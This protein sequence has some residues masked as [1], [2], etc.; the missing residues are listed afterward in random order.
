MITTDIG[1]EVAARSLAR[2]VVSLESF[3]LKVVRA[4][5]DQRTCYQ[6]VG[7]FSICPDYLHCAHYAVLIGVLTNTLETPELGCLEDDIYGHSV[8]LVGCK[9][10]SPDECVRRIVGRISSSMRQEV[11]LIASRL[12]GGH[13]LERHALFSGV[14]FE[15]RDLIFAIETEAMTRPD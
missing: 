6:F 4:S 15:P 1:P 10:Y 3:G 9:V 12:M 7:S 13:V 14:R 11:N 5:V 8:D 2:T